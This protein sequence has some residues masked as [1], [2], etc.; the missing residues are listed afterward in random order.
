MLAPGK[1][2]LGA[3]GLGKPADGTLFDGIDVPEKLEGGMLT[4]GFTFD[5]GKLVGGIFGACPKTIPELLL[6]GICG[7]DIEFVLGKLVGGILGLGK[8]GAIFGP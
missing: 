6:A 8:L 1:F 3:P 4:P 5:P 7:P 2:V